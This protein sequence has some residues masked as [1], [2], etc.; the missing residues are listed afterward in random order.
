MELGIQWRRATGRSTSCCEL[1]GFLCYWYK[2]IQVIFNYCHP[3]RTPMNH[4][5]QSLFV[6]LKNCVNTMWWKRSN[7]KWSFELWWRPSKF[8]SWLL[9]DFVV[10][11]RVAGRLYLHSCF[12][13]AIA[14]WFYY[15][16]FKCRFSRIL[17]R[18]IFRRH[19]SESNINRCD[20][21]TPENLYTV[22]RYIEMRL[23]SIVTI[24]CVGGFSKS[25]Q[26]SSLHRMQITWNSKGYFVTAV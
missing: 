2:R 16:N 20:F 21:P 1:C 10:I 11:W 7:D 6:F 17:V 4:L 13:L 25:I 12:Y 14:S 22:S 26:C 3:F 23:Q 15:S 24:R 5:E 18:Q 19:Q 9:W 8:I